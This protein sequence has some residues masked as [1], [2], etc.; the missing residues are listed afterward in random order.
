MNKTINISLNGQHFNIDENAY[1]ILKNYLKKLE[2]SFQSDEGKDEIMQDI[3]TRIAELFQGYLGI[4][5]DVV[6]TQDVEKM[7]DVMGRPEQYLDEN[8]PTENPKS[9]NNTQNKTY[10]SGDQV[11][12]KKLYRDPDEKIIAGVLAGISHYFGWNPMILRAIYFGIPMMSIFFDFGAS[13]GFFV[14]SYIILWVIMPMANTNIQKMQM[15]GTPVTV[16]TIQKNFSKEEI[17]ETVD[18]LSGFTK[19]VVSDAGPFIE[20]L[21]EVML[22][23]FK[24]FAGIF[25][26]F[27]GIGAL[28]GAFVFLFTTL[29]S[30]NYLYTV[31][32]LV[33]DNAWKFYIF[34][35]CIFF[36]ILSFGA[37]FTFLA[38]RLLSKGNTLKNSTAFLVSCMVVFFLSLIGIGV[39]G[40]LTALDF[41]EEVSFYDKDQIAT[42]VDTLYVNFNDARNHS[43]YVNNR[44]FRNT[45]GLNETLD[46]L[47]IRV[48]NDLK[49]K[50][51]PDS[52]FYLEKIYTGK[53]RDEKSARKNISSL[54]YD[55]KLEGNRLI[56]PEEMLL[57]TSD[58]YRGQELELVLYV[59][60]GKYIETENV[61]DLESLGNLKGMSESWDNEDSEALL[62]INGDTVYCFNCEGESNKVKVDERV[63]DISSEDSKVIINEDSLSVESPDGNVKIKFKE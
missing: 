56:L 61:D 36:L 27:L 35:F 62:T 10:Y 44:R 51:S 40:G 38:I 28:I 45:L 5:R 46:S 14:V 42:E 47:K 41:K 15:Y 37:F 16:D 22:K 18:N 1:D 48:N 32:D 49:I 53:G 33:F 60:Q 58:K 29:F 50:K 23:L 55:Y 25:L 43:F 19:E 34:T 17:K 11:I 57:P 13:T 2:I 3:E 7:I 59:P 6:S 54:V 4:G 21:F 8:E 20:R 24:G 12:E 39:I 30:H 26:L 52:H 9:G 63:I 31:G